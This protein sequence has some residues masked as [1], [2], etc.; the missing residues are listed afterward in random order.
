PGQQGQLVA[1]AG[2][3]ANGQPSTTI[4]PDLDNVF[5]RQVTTFVEREIAAN[6]GIRSG[7]VWNGRRQA[8][9]PININQPFNAFNVPTT[10]TDPGP[11]GRPGTSDDGASIQLF[12]LNPSLLGLPVVTVVKN[13][14]DIRND[15]YT[16]EVTANKR[17]VGGWS[18]LASFSY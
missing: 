16:W 10:V 13:L 9:G 17:Q 4:D 6:F 5:S 3:Q 1:K 18:M 8:W 12:G 15:Y 7:F 2:A 11:D 14:P